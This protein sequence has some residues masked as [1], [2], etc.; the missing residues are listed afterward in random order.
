MGMYL[1]SGNEGFQEVLNSFCYVD[2]TGIL[3][4][5]NDSINTR[6][7]L[8]CVTRPRRFGKSIAAKTISAYYDC[9]CDSGA[10][11]AGREIS[12]SSPYESHLN[13][14][15]VI[16]LDMTNIMGNTEPQNMISF[17]TE[18]ITHEL[19]SAYPRAVRGSSF[20]GTLLN[21][22]E[23]GSPK[24]IMVIDEWDAPMRER[25]ETAKDYIS[26]LR[27]LFEGGAATAKIFAA[28]YM[29]GILPIK[30][31][32]T[33]SAVSGF[34]EYSVISPDASAGCLGFTE[35]EV[36]RLCRERG[37]DFSAAKE[38]YAGYSL[39]GVMIYNP[40]SVIRALKRRKCAAYWRETA[41]IDNLL[42][43]VNR[44]FA[45]LASAISRL[46]AGEEIPADVSRFQNDIHVTNSRDDVLALLIHLGY[47]TYDSTAGTSYIPNKELRAEF[48]GLLKNP[49]YHPGR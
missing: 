33:L 5:I 6:D 39:D 10:L 41:A 31:N 23:A 3:S 9:S 19:L 49:R 13:K 40:Y 35:D 44:D 30:R 22:I 26:F 32:N 11:F 27:T 20:D 36:Q 29:T 42:S 15:N 37:L 28:A 1:N 8:I 48:A 43:H 25:P 38:W 16:F 17:I 18:N 21:A 4:L 14:Y 34:C 24:F 45:G 46:A 2:K 12:K 7:R 47:L